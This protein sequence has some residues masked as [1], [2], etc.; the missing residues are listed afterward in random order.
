MAQSDGQPQGPGSPENN[1]AGP[2]PAGEQ[3]EL[4]ETPEGPNNWGDLPPRMAEDLNQGARERAPADYLDQVDAYFRAIAQKAR[5]DASR[6]GES[7]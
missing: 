6:E 5:E 7:D 1:G 2:A 4:G 3:G